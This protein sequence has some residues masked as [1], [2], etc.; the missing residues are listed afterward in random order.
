MLSAGTLLELGGGYVLHAAWADETAALPLQKI[1]SRIADLDSDIARTTTRV[2]EVEQKRSTH[3]TTL[4]R[5]RQEAATLNRRRDTLAKELSSLE[6][7][8]QQHTAQILSAEAQLKV[9]GQLLRERQRAIFMS[10]ASPVFMQLVLEKKWDRAQRGALY[11]AKIQARDQK[12]AE[13]FRS[14]GKEAEGARIALE[15]TR[16]KQR[17]AQGEIDIRQRALKENIAAQ[18]RV[19]GDL[20]SEKEQLSQALSEM[21]AQQLRLETVMVSLTAGGTEEDFTSPAPPPKEAAIVTDNQI[22]TTSSPA[23]GPGLVPLMGKLPL[24]V[25]GSIVLRFGAAAKRPAGKVTAPYGEKS[26]GVEIAVP[27]ESEVHS[28]ASGRVI[29]A[30]MMPM[31]GV[32]VIIDHGERYYSVYGGLAKVL[33]DR[34]STIRAGERLGQVGQGA[35]F[36]AG[37]EGQQGEPTSRLY[38]EIR[39]AGQAIDPTPFWAPKSGLQRAAHS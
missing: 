12:L 14:K 39:K 37:V 21:R 35:G 29:Y 34:G 2:V 3:A 7:E 26:K 6:Q 36:E 24:P 16:T 10:A 15:G 38:F 23:E 18:E 5:L 33:V 13:Q 25:D 27:K 9:L 11:L 32:V 31:Y 17:A 30:G 8:V 19:L 28:V 1:E 22:S 4:S 20:A